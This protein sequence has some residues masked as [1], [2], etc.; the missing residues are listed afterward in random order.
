MLVLVLA[1]PAGAAADSAVKRDKGGVSKKVAKRFK[2]NG[3]ERRA[4]DIA[5]V[6]VTGQEGF[7]I[8][9]DVRFKGNVE[10]LLGRG[11]LRRAA[12]ALVLQPK[13]R[14]FKPAVIVTQGG[15]RNQRIR[16]RTASNQSGAVR[17]GRTVKFFVKGPGFSR[18]GRARVL[19]LPRAPKAARG[20]RA[21]QA[22]GVEELTDGEVE[23]IT[24]ETIQAD[25]AEIL[26]LSRNTDPEDFE[27]DELEDMLDDLEDAL[28][29]LEDYREL[30]TEAEQALEQELSRTMDPEDRAVLQAALR[31]VRV[32]QVLVGFA[33][34]VTDELADDVEEILAEECRFTSPSLAGFMAWN[35]FGPD[36]VMASG[37]YFDA[38]AGASQS[39]ITE[40]RVIVPDSG[41]TNRE[42]T[43]Q[44]CPSQLPGTE[45]I[46]PAGPRSGLRC[47]GGSLALRER[48]NMNV[49]TSPNPSPGMGGQLWA[50]QDGTLK[51][52]FPI[53][54]P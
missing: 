28:D 36:E 20:A 39:P 31:E 45:V 16:R 13:S 1:L 34:A 27:C 44:L 9:V 4:L 53:T 10:R 33:G 3:K 14:R 12:I 46:D 51:G 40:V 35:A 47:H 23:E 11:R 19:A 21:A 37:A 32:T 48:F 5:S 25:A 24:L 2:L 50:V 29:A 41:A 18:L 52:P 42:I 8:L 26:T 38:P 17:A 15:A 43:N 7:G 6:Q 49:R 30:L 22:D 54:G